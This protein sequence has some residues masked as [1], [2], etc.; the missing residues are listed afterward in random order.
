MSQSVKRREALDE[1]RRED[2][3]AAPDLDRQHQLSKRPLKLLL[4]RWC[5]FRKTYEKLHANTIYMKL[6]EIMFFRICHLC[7]V[8][9]C[10]KYMYLFIDWLKISCLPFAQT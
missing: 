8:I 9:L 5:V 6:Y 4:G 10:G 2:L 7:D 1:Q 3:P